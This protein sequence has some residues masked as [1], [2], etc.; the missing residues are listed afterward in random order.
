[1]PTRV[2]TLDI[3]FV[4]STPVGERIAFGRPHTR[5]KTSICFAKRSL[6]IHL[7]MPRHID[8]GK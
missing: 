7:Q 5:L 8:D 1:L 2:K 6:S 3:F 4:Q